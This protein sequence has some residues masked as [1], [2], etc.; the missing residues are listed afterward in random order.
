MEKVSKQIYSRITGVA[1]GRNELAF[2]MLKAYLAMLAWCS[3]DL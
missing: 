3:I 2:S 1:A